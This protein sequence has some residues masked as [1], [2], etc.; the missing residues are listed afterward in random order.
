MNILGISCFYHDSCACLLKDGRIVAAAQEERFNRSKYSEAF[1]VNAINFCLQAADLTIRDVDYVGFYEKPFLKFSRVL[2]NHIKGYP[3]TLKNFM[4][5][6]PDWLED[7]L[8]I[9]LK[10]ERDLSYKGK[11]LFIKHHL[12]HAAGAFL[13][14]P[15]QEAAILTVDGVGEWATASYGKGQGNSIQI[16]KEM[17]YPDSLGLLY[18]IVTTYL[19]FRVFEGEGK[20]MGLAGYGSPAYL[21][22]FKEI[23]TVRPD[24]SFRMDQK[25]F[26]FNRGS[27]MYNREFIRLFGPPR[28][29]GSVFQ[30][31]HYDVASSLQVFIEEVLTAMANHVYNETGLDKLCL[32]GGVFL[33]CVANYKI[34]KNCHFKDIFIQPAAGD[35]GGALGV[36]L[37][38]YNCLLKQPRNFIMTSASLG[39]E[40]SLRAIKRALLNQGLAFKEFTD[41][42]LPKYIA[43][44]LSEDKIVG[45]FQ[46]RMELGPRALGNRSILANPCNP[47][48]KDLLNEKV[49]KRE[50]FRPFA[51]AVL[52]ERVADYFELDRP[53]PF[54][55]LAPPVK[56]EKKKVIPAVTHADGTAR[57]Q[58]VN[59]EDD[60]RL[61]SLIKEFEAIS[62]V[63]V[64]INT[65]FNLKG[66]PIVCTP[67]EAIDC[68]Q[69][70]QMDCLVLENFVVERELN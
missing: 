63:P 55:L 56:E 29:P 50:S 68:F 40:F 53:S 65:S 66:E 3:F 25:F 48:M 7:R 42:D 8:I 37:Y 30:Q 4:D 57:V 14:S 6:M 1:P 67:E 11:T 34:L 24:G 32:A 19:G 38:I 43:K 33:N 31:R 9:P 69:R 18:S 12:A 62:G 41:D 2:L 61:W 16:Y 21:D 22:K 20:V 28:E 44:R 49:K 13:A 39:P 10:L 52:E 35:S 46:G 58:T 64:I 36:A 51:P 15:F 59:K 17:D 5:T 27:R 23:V 45:W 60:R 70:S 26:N 47:A 54:M